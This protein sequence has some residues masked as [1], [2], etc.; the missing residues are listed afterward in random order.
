MRP[1]DIE[2][3]DETLGLSYLF[4]TGCGWCGL[5]GHESTECPN[6]P[7]TGPQSQSYGALMEGRKRRDV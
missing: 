6:K 7:L 3:D 2:P 5:E 1:D 4:Y